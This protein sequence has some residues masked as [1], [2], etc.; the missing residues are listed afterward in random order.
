VDYDVVTIGAGHNALVASAYL[1]QAGY[2]V[3]VFE[4]RSIVG[5]AVSTQEIV[6]GY[7]FDLGGSAHILIRLTP[8]IEELQ[9]ERFGLTYLELDPLFFAPFPDDDA[10]FIYRDVAQTVDHLEHKFPGQGQAYR[11][12]IEDWRDFSLTVRDTFLESPSPFQLGKKMAFG[13]SPP[14]DWQEAMRHI[15]RPYGEVIAEYFDEE[16]LRAML[17][18]MAAQSGPPPTEP[19]TGPFVLWHPLYHEGGIARPRGGSGMLTQALKR[20]IEAHGGDVFVDMPVTEI[21]VEGRE[22]TG[23]RV[24]GEPVTARATLA[25]THVKESLGRLLPEAHRPEFI[26]NL[27]LGNGFGAILR[28]ALDRPVR[29]RAYPGREARVGLQLLCRDTQQLRS[30]YGAY[31]DGRPAQDPP[32]I[33]MTFSAVDDT[34]APP[35]G[36][37]L[38]LWAQYFP[39]QLADGLRWADIEDQ[40]ADVILDAFE[41]YAPGTRDAIVGQL[42]QHPEWLERELG[43]FR[44]N[45]MHLEMS[46]DQMFMLRPHLSLSSY[47]SHMDGLYLTGAST[48]PGGGIMGA[49]GRNAARVLL[50]DLDR[51]RR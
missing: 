18:W 30:A 3:G 44:G 8:I 32:I 42:F 39:Y 46:I 10:V 47:R 26:D 43:L 51:R 37:V 7:Q 35:G 2:R 33:A 25:G 16:K 12:F 14:M 41:E 17:A 27:R 24:H 36:E 15:T 22:A 21:L 45:V 34:L 1:A 23:V 20:H 50:K 4:R 48:H 40:V 29:Y 6:P 19:M 5:G 9:L 28:L 13:G 11:R 31:M 49:S 38:W